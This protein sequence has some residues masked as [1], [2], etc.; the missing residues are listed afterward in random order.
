MLLTK[1]SRV[2]EPLALCGAAASG[3]KAIPAADRE[4]AVSRSFIIKDD[5]ARLRAPDKSRG[6]AENRA[7]R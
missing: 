6:Y 3:A 4:A 5:V 1:K 2:T 7:A